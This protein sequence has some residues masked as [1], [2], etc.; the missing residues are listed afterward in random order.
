MIKT[1][2]GLK[3]EEVLQ[4]HD[5]TMIDRR[6]VQLAAL[7]AAKKLTDILLAEAKGDRK[8]PSGAEMTAVIFNEFENFTRKA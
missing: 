5:R 8:F 1:E 6:D 2:D 7:R 3:V 4:R